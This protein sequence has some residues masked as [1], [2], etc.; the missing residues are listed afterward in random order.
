[1]FG[2]EHVNVATFWSKTW[3]VTEIQYE[4]GETG[5]PIDKSR[6]EQNG[7]HFADGT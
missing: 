1:M 3:N 2:A 6:P 7:R 5:G 4:I